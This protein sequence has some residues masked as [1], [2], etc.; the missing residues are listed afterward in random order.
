M[1]ILKALKLLEK[2]TGAEVFLVGGYVRDYIRNKPNKDVDVV[3]KNISL[4][5]AASFLKAY[6]K[7]KIISLSQ[8]RETNPFNALLFRCFR[9]PEVEVQIT[10]PRRGKLQISDK[11]N[12]LKQD[13]KYR[14]FKFNALY[15][16][17]S[18]SSR[19]DVIDHVGGIEDLKN[20]V[21]SPITTAEEC[22]MLSPIRMLRMVRLAATTNYRIS[23]DLIK[24]TRK[25]A[26][27][28]LTVPPEVIREEFNRILLVPR[29]SRYLRLL[30]RL[31]LLKYILP[32]LDR[33]VG[34]KQDVR[35][36]KYDVFTHSIL[37]ADFLEPNLVLRLAGILHDVG[38]TDTREI[39][40]EGKDRHITFHKHEIEST[41]LARAFLDRFRY[42]SK[43]K[44]GVLNLV[45]MHMYH[46]TREYSD[47]A[48]RRF[49]KKAGITRH[50]VGD[51]GNIL[52]FKLRAGE[53]QGN[54][55]KKEPVTQR[56]LDFENR[57]RNMF[58]KGGATEVND[59]NING[60][61]IM[62]AFELKP[63]PHIGHILEYLV[64]K[65]RENKALN[66]RLDLLSLTLDY[67]KGRNGHKQENTVVLKEEGS[68]KTSP[69]YLSE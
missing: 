37:T 36:H 54:G 12:S 62:E 31:N 59:L 67:L 35:Y 26:D 33:C 25:Q 8:A 3:V 55:L 43:T 46:Y 49:V 61:V 21:I 66:N 41:R 57:I 48:V 7:C 42:D 58:E 1:K 51:L 15:L 27:R 68:E 11:T 64:G 56:Q 34:V 32:E 22:I 47:A 40:K 16:P 18:F 10:L 52:L 45:R 17:I 44:D 65:V 5:E 14:D 23:N 63:G 9:E 30:Q 38:K 53:R 50:N 19:R 13:S 6:G 69:S 24:E 60:H 20:R 28:I 4:E 29:P 2:N 39:V